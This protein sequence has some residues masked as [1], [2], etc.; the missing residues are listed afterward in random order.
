MSTHF[1]IEIP[2]EEEVLKFT[3][4]QLTY[5]EK[6]K[7]ASLTTEFK[8]GQAVIDSSLNCFYVIKYGLV[9][10]EGLKDS[11]GENWKPEKV[12]EDGIE[13]N[14][15]SSIDSLLNSKVTNGLVWA[16]NSMLEGIPDKIINP[17]T[18]REIQGVS[19]VMLDNNKKKS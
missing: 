7:I 9:S 16:A 5:K 18:G 12:N 15:D 2:Y 13:V 14:A 8:Q 3:F 11:S 1:N 17:L 6:N 10:V 4:R 19:V